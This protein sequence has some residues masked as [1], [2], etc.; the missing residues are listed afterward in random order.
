MP[1]SKGPK[2]SK[3]NAKQGPIIGKMPSLSANKTRPFRLDQGTNAKVPKG[4]NK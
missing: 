4:K 1:T 3:Q 2:F